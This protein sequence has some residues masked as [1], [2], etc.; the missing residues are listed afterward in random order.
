MSRIPSSLALSFALGFFALANTAAQAAVIHD[1]LFDGDLSNSAA[2]PTYLGV[3][4]AGSNVVIGTNHSGSDV[5][6]YLSF[7]IAPGQILQSVVVS[8]LAPQFASFTLYSN[9]TATP[10][11]LELIVLAPASGAMD[12]LQ[13]DSAPGPQPAGI[14]SLRVNMAGIDN[15][16]ILTWSA[17]FTVIPIPAAAWLFAGALGLLGWARHRGKGG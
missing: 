7:D 4:A 1:E 10:P 6:D 16:S 2:T 9:G 12:L 8:T 5:L 3:L 15:P 11:E 13:F 17:D 14:Y